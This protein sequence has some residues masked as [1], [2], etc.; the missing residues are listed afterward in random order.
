MRDQMLATFIRLDKK[1]LE[2]ARD[3]S[4]GKLSAVLLTVIKLDFVTLQDFH[5]AQMHNR[6]PYQQT[7]ESWKTGY[8]LVLKACKDSLATKP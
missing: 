2:A 8:G 1:A 3:A 7:L 5:T 6:K 4:S